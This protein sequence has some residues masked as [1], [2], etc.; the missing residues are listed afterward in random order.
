MQQVHCPFSRTLSLLL[1]PWQ[2]PKCWLSQRGT[3]VCSSGATQWPL[4][5]ECPQIRNLLRLCFFLPTLSHQNGWFNPYPFV[6]C[7][8]SSSKRTS[9]F[10]VPI[11]GKPT[12]AQSPPEVSIWPQEIPTFPYQVKQ[13]A[14]HSISELPPTPAISLLLLFL[15][16]SAVTHAVGFGF[17]GTITFKEETI[18]YF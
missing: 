6:P 10:K 2:A 7:V 18:T 12:E 3:F 15:T 14:P 11:K 5:A 4:P 17:R 13:T 1:P 8:F 16:G 9:L